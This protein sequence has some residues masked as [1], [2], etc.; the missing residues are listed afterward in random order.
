MMARAGDD[1]KRRR[2]AA[3]QDWTTAPRAPVWLVEQV[4]APGDPADQDNARADGS[5]GKVDGAGGA[6]RDAAALPD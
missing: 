4:L 2:Q 5:A 1:V 3:P 6:V